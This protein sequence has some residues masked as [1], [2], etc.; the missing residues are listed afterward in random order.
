[1][2]KLR[3]LSSRRFSLPEAALALSIVLALAFP[4]L[5]AD[6]PG[7]GQTVT[8]TY[9]S[10][11]ESLFQT[12]VVDIGLE[13]LG[14]T[15]KA[16]LALD[17][18]AMY[19]ASGTG[20]VTFTASAWDPL[21]NAFFDKA[22]GTGKL[23]KVGELIRGASQG[24]F[25]DKK[26][27]DAYKITNV[28]Q[29]KD[30]KIAALFSD[31]T[32]SMAQLIGCPPGWGCERVI[33]HQLTAYD[34]RKTVHHVQGQM[35]VLAT[36]VIARYKEGKPVL[37][38]TY[39]P[40]WLSQVLVPGRDVEYL[41]VPF[42]SLPE[43]SDTA[44][45]KLPDGRNIGFTINTVRVVANKDFVSK[46]PAAAKWFELVTIPIADVNTENY[47]IYEGQKSTADIRRHAE[48]WVAK[49]KAQVDGW[50]AEAAKAAN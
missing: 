4:A 6:M 12:E 48:E 17:I 2:I 9:D 49:N 8:P 13:R 7:K 31:G 22:G 28:E 14:Y 50:V 29:L 46:N 10:T 33:E 5:A 1:M 18:P 30:P 3:H 38:Y 26:T 37:Y 21:Q 34:L 39:T 11:A 16:P 23:V 45:T 27:A 24:Y 44:N 36:D 42:T 43:N 32:S 25:I 20:D 15:V 40:L 19:L 35:A 47:E 41:Q